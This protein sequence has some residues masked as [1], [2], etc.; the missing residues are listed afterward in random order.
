VLIRRAKTGCRGG[1]DGVHASR[2]STDH[3]ACPRLRQFLR[4]QSAQSGIVPGTHR[5][6]KW[7]TFYA[8]D[9][10]DAQ[11]RFFDHYLRKPIPVRRLG[12]ASRCGRV[13]TTSQ[14]SARPTPGRRQKSNGPNCIWQQRAYAWSQRPSPA[15]SGSQSD[16]VARAGVGRC[17]RTSTDRADARHAVDRGGR[18]RRPRPFRERREVGSRPLCAVRR[19][20]AADAQGRTSLCSDI[21]YR[22]CGRSVLDIKPGIGPSSLNQ[23][24]RLTIWRGCGHSSQMK[25]LFDPG[26]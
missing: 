26:W 16:P 5:S 1:V 12:S 19:G 13:V 6:G 20:K 23:S 21:G 8:E 15:T 22:R 17:R 4:Q 24:G 14:P 9:A 25:S 11:Q 2:S 3:G 7:A 18:H 10:R